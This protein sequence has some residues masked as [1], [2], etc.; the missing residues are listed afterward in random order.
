MDDKDLEWSKDGEA[1]Q[2]HP[3][4]DGDFMATVEK[5]AEEGRENSRM[6]DEVIKEMDTLQLE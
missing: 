1:E 2:M 4:N 6:K 5:R 3:A